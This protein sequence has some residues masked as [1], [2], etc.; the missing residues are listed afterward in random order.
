ME[1][2][3]QLELAQVLKLSPTLLQSMGILQMTTLELADYLQDLALENPVMEE[4]PGARETAWDAFASRVPWLAGERIAS[5]GPAVGEP[6]RRD[7]EPESLAFFLAEQLD[8]QGL[9]QP[10]LAVCRYLVDL[11][12]DHGRLDPE[13]LADLTQAG[14]PE[15]LLEE[16]VAAL[17]SLD[18][19]GVG[20]RSAGESLA[21]QLKRQPGDHRVALA[22]CEKGLD[23]LAREQYGAL[24][25]RLGVPRKQVEA[26]AQA[27]RALDPNPVGA[28]AVQGEIEYLRP[29]AW[30]AEIDGTLQVF[31][32]QWDLRPPAAG[33]PDAVPHRL[34][35]GPRGL[36]PGED[37]GAGAFAGAGA[38]G[39]LGPASLYGEPHAGTQGPA[40]PP[41]GLSP[42]LVLWPGGGGGALS[43]RGP[44]P[45]CPAGGGGGFPMS[46]QRP[47]IDGTPPGGGHPRGPANGGQVPPGTGTAAVLPEETVKKHPRQQ[48]CRGCFGRGAGGNGSILPPETF[49][50]GE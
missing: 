3:Q 45:H 15:A 40:V 27:I 23:L 41:G 32:N 12:D 8:R 11:L 10:L 34:G 29:D 43:P 42:G 2:K 39:D 48:R 31:V 44:G 46:L 36:F 7:R 50:M 9:D 25:R 1:H 4:T 20:A 28:W 38:G 49:L 5:G 14:V 33:D 16:G 6:G 37:F 17:Q 24:A 13:D 35:G 19:A 22:I 18:P 30:V 47:G 21:L 26:A